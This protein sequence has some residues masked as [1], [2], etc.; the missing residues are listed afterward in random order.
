M[1]PF[2]VRDIVKIEFDEM[3]LTK[4]QVE[5]SI[6]NIETDR[7]LLDY[8]RISPY[9]YQFLHEGDEIKMYYYS[10]SGIFIF[11]SIIITAPTE[12]AFE[13][14]LPQDYTKIQRRDY[15]RVAVDLAVQ[16]ADR[17]K[18]LINTSRTINIGGNS[19]R[20]YS[21]ENLVFGKVY[22]AYLYLSDTDIVKLTGAIIK[23]EGDE[24]VMEF[25]KINSKD[26]DKI[27]KLCIYLQ[28][29]N[30]NRKKNSL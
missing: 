30:I 16:I 28:S 23:I 8:S 17:N 21:K 6:R 19:I 7:L 3:G 29:Q 27:L 13:I 20:F 22:D 11:D 10:E 9:Y 12:L 14:E 4:K 1:P 26:R 5:C 18:G 15:I 25:T 24:Y 2:N